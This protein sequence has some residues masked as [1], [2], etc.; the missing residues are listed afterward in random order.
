MRTLPR[1]QVRPHFAAGV[2]P[3]LRVLQQHERGLEERSEF[4]R[5]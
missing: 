5:P 4:Y 2:L 1:W 3:D